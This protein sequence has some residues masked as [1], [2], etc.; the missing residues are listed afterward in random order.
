MRQNIFIAFFLSIACL[1]PDGAHAETIKV[2]ED[3]S[4]GINGANYTATL[5][6]GTILGFY[7]YRSMENSYHFCGA[8]STAETLS[9]PDG[10]T[11][12][13]TDHEITMI[14][15]YGEL[16]LTQATTVKRLIFGPSINTI[17]GAIPASVSELHLTSITPPDLNSSSYIHVGTAVYV[18]QSGYRSY[19][20]L[21]ADKESGWYDKKVTY[22]G[23]TPNCITVNVKVAGSFANELLKSTDQ[24]TD[25]DELTVTGHLNDA[26]MQNFNKIRFLSKLDLTQTDIT[27]IGGC[28]GLGLLTELRLPAT[29]VRVNDNAFTGCAKLS[30]FDFSQIKTIGA[31]AFQDCRSL[32][33][34]DGGSVKEIGNASFSGCTGLITVDMPSVTIIPDE[35]FYKCDSLASVNL[36]NVTHIRGRAFSFCRNITELDIPNLESIT[37][38]SAFDECRKLSKINLGTKLDA[39][40]DNTFSGCIS[41]SDIDIPSSVRS[42][43]YKCL[44]SCPITDLIIPEGV[45]RI[46]RDI[47]FDYGTTVLS[48]VSLPSTLQY[49]DEDA[50]S[51]C[52]TIRDVYC[53]IV[54]PPAIS[55]IENVSNITLHVP[56]V[57]LNVYR[58]HETWYK[59]RQILPIEENIDK[60]TVNGD[61]TLYDYNGLADEID[62]TLS[63]TPATDNWSDDKTAAHLSVN[64]GSPLNVGKFTMYQN[65]YDRD[66]YYDDVTD[67]TIEGIY[68]NCTTLIGENEISASEVRMFLTVSPGQWNF[69]SFPFDVNVSDIRMP[70]GVLWVIRKYSGADRAAMNGNTWQNMI[71]GTTLRA[72]EGYILHCKDTNVN[73]DYY[74]SVTMEVSAVDNSDKNRIFNHNDAVID[75]AEYPSQ[76]AHNSSW[77]L[78]GNPYPAY[79]NIRYMDFEAPITVYNGDGYMAYSPLDDN[80]ILSPDESFF[81]QRSAANASVTFSKSGRQ[82]QPQE[83]PTGS[84][85][86]AC[87]T[88]SDTRH[89]R[90]V[91]NFYIT[92]ARYT[93]R[94]RLVINPEAR[95]DYEPERDASKFMSTNTLVPQIYFH[96]RGIRYSINECPQNNE[97]YILGI[98]AGETGEYT[99]CLDRTQA[100][101]KV[102]VTDLETGVE[103]NIGQSDYTF[104]ATKGYDDSRFRVKVSA[105]VSGINDIEA[106]NIGESG[107]VYNLKGQKVDD[108][109]KG[110]VIVNGKKVIK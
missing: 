51:G 62:L 10:I 11:I 82:H 33:Y 106:D 37:G 64:A 18:P 107:H 25:V 49:I 71:E 97:G 102:I 58:L 35:A 56:S 59:F 23:Y 45:I 88:F 95:A 85:R 1:M 79:F 61:F 67:E 99:L 66:Y 30:D 110:I 90:D 13:A 27:S 47:L 50:F 76:Y 5:D 48:T 91:L 104:F 39:I 98:Y 26:D 20:V 94:T 75:L 65:W 55:G 8:I 34:I 77:N 103:V 15:C 36:T 38:S 3:Y 31:D 109:T 81:V 78:I 80:Y 101:G 44:A 74:S 46:G 40:P 86:A 53:H 73:D 41:L 16:D 24:L 2:V 21:V 54:A 72:N 68:N 17:D 108:D 69:I 63:Y 32:T 22:E 7:E 12:G 4:S 9:I 43:G 89:K 87:Q 28:A 52:R 70:D 29:V 14:G 60:L 57:S 105:D 84:L 92:N 100:Q 96:D 42:L 83:E 93:D 19:Q 6:D